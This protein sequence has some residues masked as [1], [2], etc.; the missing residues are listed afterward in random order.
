MQ[1]RQ[2]RQEMSKAAAEEVMYWFNSP[3]HTI[4]HVSDE[5]RYVD[6]SSVMNVIYRSEQRNKLTSIVFVESHAQDKQGLIIADIVKHSDALGQ[7]VLVN[8]HFTKETFEALKWA[9][10]ENTSIWTL[11][12]AQEDSVTYKD[13]LDMLWFVARYGPPRDVDSHWSVRMPTYAPLASELE[14]NYYT[15]YKEESDKLGHPSML[16]LLVNVHEP[17]CRNRAVKRFVY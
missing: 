3:E 13:L 7:L 16:E 10:L 6:L 1:N 9:L 14:P 12:F 15:D 8:N 11:V 4:L 17:R 2:Q 5:L